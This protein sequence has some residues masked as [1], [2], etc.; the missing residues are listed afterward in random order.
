MMAV[1]I[2]SDSTLQV[3]QTTELFQ[4]GLLAPHNNA[5]STRYA[6]TDDGQRF[7]IAPGS[8][9]PVASGDPVP[10]TAIVNWTALL[11]KK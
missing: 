6:V 10:I 8:T 5:L 4:S 1:S 7:L 11:R 9:V 3:G 2:K